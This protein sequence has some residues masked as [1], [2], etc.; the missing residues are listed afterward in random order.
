MS[1]MLTVIYWRDIPAQVTAKGEAGS[2]RVQLSDRFQKAIDAA[3]M[4]AGLVDMDLYLEEWR[5]EAR[6][7]G[8]DLEGEVA[9]E[10]ERLEAAFDRDLLLQLARSGGRLLAIAAD[11]EAGALP[12]RP[13]GCFEIRPRTGREWRLSPG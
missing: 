7:C 10:A 5:Q 9:D 6:P 13:A 11:E 4:K 12:R 1:A 2:A 3:A 8:D